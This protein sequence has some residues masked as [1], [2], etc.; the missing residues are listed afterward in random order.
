ML[1]WLRAEL[2]LQK[3]PSS[4]WR[5]WE[6]VAAKKFPLDKRENLSQ[7]EEGELRPWK[8]SNLFWSSLELPGLHHFAQTP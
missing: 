2:P 6:Q 7:G 1:A 3:E 5:H 8:Y 4:C